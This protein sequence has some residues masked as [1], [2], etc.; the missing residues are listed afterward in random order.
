VLKSRDRNRAAPT[1][2][3]PGLYL[4]AVEYDASWALPSNADIGGLEELLF[5]AE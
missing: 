4:A 5:A 2:A 1:F 3:A